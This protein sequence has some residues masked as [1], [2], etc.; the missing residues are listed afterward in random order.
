MNGVAY[1]LE[2]EPGTTLL[3]AVRDSVGLTGAKEG[4]DDSECGACMM[5]LDGKPVKGLH[6]ALAGKA[7]R[8][9]AP[10]R[11]RDHA[12]EPAVEHEE[13][14]Q[15]EAALLQQAFAAM[16]VMHRDELAQDG[17]FGT[18]YAAANAGLL[19]TAKGAAALLVPLSSVLVSALGDW[20]AVF[21]VAS[22]MNALAALLA[23]FVL[24][25]L[26]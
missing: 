2:V 19:Y 17:T 3:F 26:P 1:P 16:A 11:A 23:W 20:H 15:L 21:M 25:P 14:H 12:L 5:L 4:C 24:R 13:L 6:V 9:L 7:Q 8:H 10:L 22:A 18:K